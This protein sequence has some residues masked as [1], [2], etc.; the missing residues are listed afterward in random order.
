MKKRIIHKE[1]AA[2]RWFQFS[3]IEQFANI[4]S[5]VE[6]T[7]RYKQKGDHE[8]SQAACQ[9]ALELLDLSI[10]DP[11]NKKRLKEILRIRYMF[12]DHYMGINEYN[13]TDEFWQKYF[14]YFAYAYAGQ[15]GR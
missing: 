5:E 12:A 2:G 1:L 13:F 6:R 8:D 15:R 11:K 14:D 9:R 3:L 4:G 10:A 7:I